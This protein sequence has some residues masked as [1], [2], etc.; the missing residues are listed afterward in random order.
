M[1]CKCHHCGRNYSVDLLVP[2]AVWEQIK[3]SGKPAGAGLLCGVCII[4]RMEKLGYAAL[5][6]GDGKHKCRFIT[7]PDIGTYFLPECM[8][9]AV[10]GLAGCTCGGK[11]DY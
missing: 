7:E 10:N 11:P 4:E 2:D 8:G 9:G 3:P 6:F 5:V 1:T